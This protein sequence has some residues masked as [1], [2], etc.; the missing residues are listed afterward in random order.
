MESTNRDGFLFS[1]AHMGGL[2]FASNRG[3][4]NQ[5]RPGSANRWR[6]IPANQHGQTFLD[7]DGSM[8]SIN[9]DS[10]FVYGG[11]GG[12]IDQI[13]G[14]L[15]MNDLSNSIIL[16]QNGYYMHKPVEDFMQQQ[17]E[18][19]HRGS[20]IESYARAKEMV[21]GGQ[22][23]VFI[24]HGDWHNA[25]VSRLCAGLCREG[26]LHCYVD[27]RRGRLGRMG[28]KIEEQS[29]SGHSKDEGR[30]GDTNDEDMLVRMHDAK[31]AILKCSAFVVILS[32]KTL[33]SQLVKDQ[34]AFAEDKGKKIIPV[35][36]NPLEFSLDMLYSLSRSDFYHFF[37][38]G[39]M[40]GFE[41]S[42]DQ[43][44][45]TLREEMFGISVEQEQHV[46][47]FSRLP[48]TLSL[49]QLSSFSSQHASDMVLRRRHGSS[50]SLSGGDTGSVIGSDRGWIEPPVSARMNHSFLSSSS[51][52]GTI[53]SGQPP[54]ALNSDMSLQQAMLGNFSTLMRRIT[55]EIDNDDMD[56]GDEHLLPHSEDH[57][58]DD[59]DLDVE[60]DPVMMQSVSDMGEDEL[61]V[62]DRGLFGSN[63]SSNSNYAFR[64]IHQPRPGR[65]SSIM[66]N[67][68]RSVS[69]LERE[70]ADTGLSIDTV[71]PA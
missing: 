25:F 63:R 3:R 47:S 38:S 31:E 7:I 53:A 60:F 8:I 13:F 46:T 37:T 17:Q 24:C 62:S 61:A 5:A 36:V 10:S 27:R 43:V 49:G 50:H 39:D 54:R 32:E 69:I 67:S 44:L 15:G 45:A 16:N 23:F 70:S 59:L 19:A 51:G 4:S 40:P 66:S 48:K 33:A 41:K 71:R 68:A 12:A 34:L 35:V 20:V 42:L 21:E 14:G 65:L 29:E 52:N 11:A 28:S 57:V 30:D 55:D 1:S 18:V 64:A 22:Q 56:E 9:N 2:Q 58:G 6:G 26:G